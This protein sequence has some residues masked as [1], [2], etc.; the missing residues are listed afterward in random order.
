MK[1]F[2]LFIAIQSLLLAH[3]QT[4]VT[5]RIV[6]CDGKPPLR[7][8][9]L[10]QH[11]DQ[12]VAPTVV[13]ADNNGYFE[14]QVTPGIRYTFTFC[15]VNHRS[16][17][18]WI[19][20]RN[21]KPI[22]IDVRLGAYTYRKKFSDVRI[23]GGFNDF[24]FENA[25]KMKRQQDGTFTISMRSDSERFRYQL[26]NVEIA[27]SINGTEALEYEPDREGDYISIVT[28]INGRVKI[29]FDPRK[30]IRSDAKAEIVTTDELAE[31][32]ARLRAEFDSVDA[33]VQADATAY[34]KT[35]ENFDEYSFD[36][37]SLIE[38]CE[39]R[40][41]ATEDITLKMLLRIHQYELN[42]INMKRGDSAAA[43][44]MLDQIQF[45]SPVFYYRLNVL[46]Q[47][48]NT[49]GSDATTDAYLERYIDSP[50]DTLLKEDLLSDMIRSG[51]CQPNLERMKKRYQ[52]Y[53]REFGD[54]WKAPMIRTLYNPDPIIQ[55]GKQLPHFTARLAADTT[56]IISETGLKGRTCL[57][58]FGVPET[59]NLW[60]SAAEL[61][62]LFKRYHRRGF[63]ILVFWIEKDPAIIRRTVTQLGLQPWINFYLPKMFGDPTLK[64]FDVNVAPYSFLVNA[65]GMI[66]ATENDLHESTLELQ[67]RNALK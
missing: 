63:E 14:A 17:E 36:V 39:K 57:V 35:H 60:Y 50:A 1:L 4:T 43:Q 32:E 61:K 16:C 37:K 54:S 33:L 30:L 38:M 41:L 28:P 24:Q 23:T 51:Q 62:S 42:S 18:R 25:V 6:G 34:R 15:G 29:V 46:Y 64:A 66:V 31:L 67:I 9:V 2:T 12:L 3:E 53:M 65:S 49:C 13:Q 10:I 11:H 52:L 55:R 56:K 47:L 7:S 48:L 44:R 8:H 45:E 22:H 58:L 40:I 21:T 26:L 27:R 5:G 20:V 19:F 59:L